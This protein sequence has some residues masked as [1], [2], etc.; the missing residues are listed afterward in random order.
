MLL[1]AGTVPLKEMPLTVGEIRLEGD[2][3]AVDGYRIPRTQGT[4]AMVNHNI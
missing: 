2:F 1:I 4:G 3:L